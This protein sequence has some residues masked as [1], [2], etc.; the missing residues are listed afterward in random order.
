MGSQFKAVSLKSSGIKKLRCHLA[1]L[2]P[3]LELNIVSRTV[4]MVHKFEKSLEREAVHRFFQY[5]IRPTDWSVQN[6]VRYGCISLDSMHSYGT[7]GSVRYGPVP[8]G[9]RYGYQLP[10][11]G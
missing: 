5:G 2:V 3:E 10:I 6:G 4:T 7:G 11:F 1:G 9:V 8:Y